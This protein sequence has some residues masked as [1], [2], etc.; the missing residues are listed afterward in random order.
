MEN[1]DWCRN[2]IDRFVLASL[3][4]EGL[5][6]A[7]EADRPTLLRRLHW[8][9]TGLPP[10]RDHLHTDQSLSQRAEILLASPA[11]GERWGRRWLDVVRYADSNGQDENKAMAEAWRYRDYVVDAFNAD[12]P[13]DRFVREQIAGDLLPGT[14]EERIRATVA[15]GFLVLGPKRLAEQ[16]KDKMI[17]DI[18]DEQVDTIGHGFLGVS[19][20]CARCHDHFYEPVSQRDYFAM[21]GILASTRVMADR[22]HVSK[23]Q[24]REIAPESLRQA[25]AAHA[26]ELKAVKAQLASAKADADVAYAPRLREQAEGYLRAAAG[27]EDSALNP[28]I[29]QRWAAH[30][31]KPVFDVWRQQP[32][33]IAEFANTLA[34][35]STVTE[36]G[37]YLPGPV[38]TAWKAG[39]KPIDI[40]HEPALEPDTYTLMA[41][42]RYT[43][44]KAHHDLRRWIISKN[45][46]EW[47]QG[48]YS[49]FISQGYA[50]AY[51]A[52]DGGQ[53]RQISV[54]SKDGS[55][56]S[57]EW[58][59][60]ACSFDG[61][62][63]RIFVNGK[64]SGDVA[65]DRPW[66]HGKGHLRIAG[67][68]DNFNACPD[69]DIDEA[70]IYGRALSVAEIANAARK[71]EQATADGL[72]RAFDFT[73]PEAEDEM[74]ANPKIWQAANQMFALPKD[75]KE[76]WTHHERAAIDALAA[77]EKALAK[78][79]PTMI[80]AMAASEGKVESLRLHVRGDHLRPSGDPVPR[81][82]P[83]ALG[84]ASTPVADGASGRLELANWIANSANPLTARV[85]VNRIWQGHFGYGLVRTPNNF[86]VRGQ[87]PTHP[88][89]LDYLA[90]EFVASGWSIKALH[91]LILDSAT[92]RMQAGTGDNR[93]LAHASRYRLDAEMVRDGMLSLSGL[94]D[95]TRG[96]PTAKLPNHDY[97]PKDLNYDSRRHALYMPIIRD[98]LAESLEVFGF[99][100]P[101]RST[102]RRDRSVLPQQ[103]LYLL[104]SD[105]A[106]ESAKALGARAESVT[107]LYE[108]ILS[109]PPTS[110]ES[111]RADALVAETD[112]ATL[113]HALLTSNEFLYIE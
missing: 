14:E 10:T 34:R 91:R 79:A 2:G 41:W 9:M 109:R 87:P 58:T 31:R 97:T 56:K 1:A 105:I 60:V 23:W 4:R 51:L 71:P 98:R 88:E 102:G 21:A 78:S 59:H 48:H 39:A 25:I 112:L 8:V 72:I 70:R 101:S 35:W 29:V 73:P 67:R 90:S 64:A 44:S 86:G 53:S 36:T 11:Y 68:A 75:R 42:V 22:A 13:F 63:L 7:P 57:G 28:A 12:L 80:R 62:R 33:R 17:Y 74:L 103:T 108:H 65:V 96:G 45:E 61:K 106:R 50:G 26:K 16:D 19:L 113:A 18:I 110:A 92:W 15:T 6:P 107:W 30:W 27:T 82:M 104:N 5:E 95:S 66:Q 54:V 55:L 69:V 83:S 32:D 52:P 76:A 93:Q 100:Q 37:N 84:L 40:P 77:R 46:S 24:E 49:L 47:H 89:L 111:A 3:K 85:I 81:G 38:G 20:G 94:L 43:F 99:A